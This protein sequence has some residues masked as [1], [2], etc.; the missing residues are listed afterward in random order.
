MSSQGFDAGSV[1]QSTWFA[2]GGAVVLLISTFVS[3][4][5]A[6]GRGAAGWDTGALGKLV[7]FVALISIV[8]VVI[9]HMGID[10]SGSP[11][12]FSIPVVLAVLAADAV[13]LVLLRFCDT[14]DGLDWAWGLYLALIA[15]AAL[16]Y[17]AWLKLQE[18]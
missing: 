11:V 5:K 13:Q 4:W 7:F 14:P 15:S 3:W 9:D 1:R 8:L 12:P 10:L 16:A 18:R 17:G 6:G 2:G